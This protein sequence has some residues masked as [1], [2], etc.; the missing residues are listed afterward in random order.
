M[1]AKLTSVLGAWQEIKTMINQPV[2]AIST[3]N[4]LL[5]PILGVGDIG[6]KVSKGKYKGMDKYLYGIKT[7]TI[8]WWSG[9]EK[10]IDFENQ[11]NVFTIFNNKYN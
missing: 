7:Y 9:I 11:D 2:A 4:A 6:D 8:P 10:T 1:D 5:Y 3:V